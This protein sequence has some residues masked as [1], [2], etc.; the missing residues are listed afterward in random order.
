MAA[1]RDLWTLIVDIKGGTYVSQF[2]AD[3][4]EAALAQFNAT[5]PAGPEIGPTLAERGGD[6]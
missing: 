1:A 5:R 2:L 4:P 6:T 3:S